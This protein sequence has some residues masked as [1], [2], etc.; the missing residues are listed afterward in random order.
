MSKY[1]R[2]IKPGISI[3]V[4]DVL[5]AF[6]VTCTA[7]AHAI[8]KMLAPGQRGVKTSLQDKQE[9]IQSL[10]RSIELEG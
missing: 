9:A 2:E 6:G 1:N 3:D 8:K 5:I 7:S 4:Y 10:R